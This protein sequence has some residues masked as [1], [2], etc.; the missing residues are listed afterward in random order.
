MFDYLKKFSKSYEDVPKFIL[1]SFIEA[2][3]STGD[4]IKLVDKDFAEYLT[5]INFNDTAVFIVSDHGLHSG[6]NFMLDTYSARIENSLALF[7][8]LLPNWYLKE[9]VG[10]KDVLLK[11][12][13]SLVTPA[14][15][16]ETLKEFLPEQSKLEK[17]SHQEGRSIFNPI[18]SSRTCE[19]ASIPLNFCRCQTFL[20]N[21]SNP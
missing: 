19:E 13:Q 15:I 9:N 18:S 1:A 7:Y 11:N 16:F 4:V 20:P 14:D 17:F 2:H 8:L 5:T 12:E 10:L 3:E 6:L 21:Q